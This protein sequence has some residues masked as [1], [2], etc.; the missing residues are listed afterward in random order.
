MGWKAA[1]ARTDQGLSCGVY[2]SEFDSAG[3]KIQIHPTRGIGGRTV[4]TAA[5]SG[6]SCRQRRDRQIDGH[7]R[8]QSRSRPD[9]DEYRGTTVRPAQ[10]RRVVTLWPGKRITGL[11]RFYCLQFGIKGTKWRSVEL[12]LWFFADRQSGGSVPIKRRAGAVPRQPAW[13]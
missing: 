10:H 13:H 11:T 5:T 9:H 2:Q 8:V 7:R 4:G 3:S 6:E 1:A 12:G